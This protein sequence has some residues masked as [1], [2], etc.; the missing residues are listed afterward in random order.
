MLLGITLVL[1]GNLVEK[2]PKNR[3]WVQKLRLS[4][5]KLNFFWIAMINGNNNMQSETSFWIFWVSN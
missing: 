5:S 1:S 4:L 2:E 3:D